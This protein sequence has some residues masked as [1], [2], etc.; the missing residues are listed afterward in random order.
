MEKLAVECFA[1][2]IKKI[3]ATY[4][5]AEILDRDNRLLAT[6]EAS[7]I[8]DGSSPE[9]HLLELSEKDADNLAR[10]A[11]TLR[12]S[13]GTTQKIVRCSRCDVTK[14]SKHFHIEVQA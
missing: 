6:G 7:P 3:R 1:E 5:P 8:D 9:F 10:N 11:S 4:V 13:D 14:H 12:R 2:D